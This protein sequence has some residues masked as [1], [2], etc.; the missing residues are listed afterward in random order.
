M[1]RKTWNLCPGFTVR[2]LR[3]T[4]QTLCLDNS[5]HSCHSCHVTTLLNTYFTERKSL[6]TALMSKCTFYQNFLKLF[7]ETQL[8]TFKKIC[9]FIDIHCNKIWC[10]PCKFLCCPGPF[11]KPSSKVGG[12]NTPKSERTQE[13]NL[14]TPFDQRMKHKLREKNLV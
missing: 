11:W 1:L 4:D 5:C 9:F 13:H 8:Q 14:Q 12:K 7:T 10:L 3:L 6:I 2:P